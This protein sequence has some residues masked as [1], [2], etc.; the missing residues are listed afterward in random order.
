MHRTPMMGMKIWV[1]IRST[2]TTCLAISMPTTHIAKDASKRMAATSIMKLGCSKLII[3]P[4][5]TPCSMS[6]PSSMAAGGLPGMPRFKSGIMAPPTQAL[7]ATSV[8]STAVYSP[9][10]NRSGCLD[11]FLAAP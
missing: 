7:L 11:A 8:D 2:L 9:L 1:G 4:G 10:P 3:G 6:A 5:V